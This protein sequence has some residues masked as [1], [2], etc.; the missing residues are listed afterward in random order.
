MTS[1][2]IINL[3][4]FILVLTLSS[5]PNGISAQDEEGSEEKEQV[6]TRASLS[7]VQKNDDVIELRML[8]RAK[9]DGRYTGLPLLD[10]TFAATTD[11]SEVSLGKATTGDDG[12]ATLSVNAK[13][14]PRDTANRMNLIAEFDGNEAF[15]GSDD[16][17]EILPA[18]L[19]LEP[20][21]EDSSLAVQVTLTAGDEPV[22]DEDIS[23]FVKRLFRPLKVGE[24][25]TDEDGMV[26]I[27]FPMGMPGDPEGNLEIYAF[28]EDHSDFGN[29]KTT[30]TQ[31]WGT[32]VS[33]KL[34]DMPRAL[35]SPNPPLWMVLA[36]IVLMG[37]VWGHYGVIVY[38]LLQI[39]REGQ[40]G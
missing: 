15:K 33:D 30:I 37:A 26:T 4:G 2:K 1:F 22:A 7:C 38:K 5:F 14:I 36:F 28:L 23:L 31:A 18:L 34:E 13:D 19:A 35:W 17:I 12:I 29:M 8:M 27:D 39:K 3:F 16:D 25:T 32:P 10:V 20:V 6:R 11:S 24:G 21:E 9:I 40:E